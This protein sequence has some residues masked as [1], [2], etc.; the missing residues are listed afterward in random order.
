[1]RPIAIGSGARIVHRRRATLGNQ[2]QGIAWRQIERVT[3]P[4]R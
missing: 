3:L 2:E 4:G 1:V